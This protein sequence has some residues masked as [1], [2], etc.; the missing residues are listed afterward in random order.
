M[1]HSLTEAFLLC[2]GDSQRLGF[3]KEMLRVDGMP[4]AV[5]MV[6]RLRRLFSAVAVVSNHPGYLEHFLRAGEHDGVPIYPDVFGGLGPLAGIH[7]GLEHSKTD[8]AFFIGCDMPLVPD[9]VIG[10]LSAAASHSSAQ[11][12]VAR[13]ERGPE[14]LCG[15]YRKSLLPT[16]AARLATGHDLSATDFVAEIRTEYLDVRSGAASCFRDVDGPEDMA[17]LRE[18]FDEVEP[19]PV[20][21]QKVTRLGGPPLEEDIVVEERA[22]AFHVNGVPLVTML[23]LPIALRE[24][25]V[26]FLAYLGLIRRHSEILRLEPAY[27]AGR[28]SVELSVDDDS[29]RKAVRLQI[30]STCGSGVYGPSVPPMAPAAGSDSFRVHKD[31]ILRILRKLRKMAPVF[32]RTGATHQ[33]AFSDGRT[34]VHFYEDVGRHNAIDKVI[35]RCLMTGTDTGCGLLLATGRLNAEMVVK[36]LR[37]GIPVAAT[38]SAPTAHAV[39]LARQGG[40]TVV[41]FARGGRLNVYTYPGRLTDD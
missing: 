29:L 21:R 18:V 11:A 27:D 7:A 38:R 4:L 34:V 8:R 1:C 6:E 25:T 35:G 28:V 9:E 37:Q 10:R 13:S 36:A 16:L 20:R 14:P 5:A 23:C 17:L 22:F 32:A 2:G 24:L 39:E 31:H 26:G 15:V 30:S 3:P 19:L 40:L 41:G 33:A 12:V